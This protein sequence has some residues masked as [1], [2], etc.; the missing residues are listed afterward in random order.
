MSTERFKPPAATPEK[1]EDTEK[2]VHHVEEVVAR[3]SEIRQACLENPNSP[4]CNV[5]LLHDE[6]EHSE[7]A[8]VFKHYED[9]KVLSITDITNSITRVAAYFEGELPNIESGS[10]E[11]KFATE[12]Y[13]LL[14][15]RADEIRTGVQRYVRT[16]SQFFQLKKQQLRLDPEDYKDK[17]VEIDKRRRATHDALI[18]TLSIYSKVVNDI[19]NYGFLENYTVVPWDYGEMLEEIADNEKN[20]I[21]FSPKLLLNRDLVKDWAISAHLFEQLNQIGTIKEN[22]TTK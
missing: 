14:R 2:P 15:M 20:I 4:M 9:H 10:D 22:G 17:L 6:I 1:N 19:K 8:E 3:T 13:N 5:Q 16:L 12:K 21:V 7:V 18:S 11:H